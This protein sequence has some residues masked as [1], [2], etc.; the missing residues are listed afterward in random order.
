VVKAMNDDRELLQRFVD[1]HDED[2]FAQIVARHL[3]L[4]YS[5]A[6][7]QVGGD[8]HLAQDVAQTVFAD[9][10]RKASLLV[11]HPVLAGW[12]HTSTHHAAA[13]AVRAER[14]RRQRE[15]EAHAMQELS[16][17]TPTDA[18]WARVRPVL[19]DA[20][21]RL[22]HTDRDALLLRFF[23]GRNFAE[24]GTAL[25]LTES[26]ARMR[27]E[28]AMEKLRG[29]LERR[30]IRSTM[31][32]LGAVL[33]TEAVAAP[34]AGLA[35]AITTSALAATGGGAAAGFLT[36]IGMSKIQ[37]SILAVAA[38]A[39][40]TTV[41]MQLH[42][43][44]K[45][46]AEVDAV[47]VA[48]AALPDLQASIAR[49][50]A[51]VRA[52]V[53]NRPEPAQLVKMREERAGLLA[54]LKELDARGVGVRAPQAVGAR[55]AP[56]VVGPVFD[57]KELDV[58]PAPLSQPRPAWPAELRGIPGDAVLSFVITP[59][60]EVADIVAED[61]SHP[62]YVLAAI[63]AVSGW[64]FKPGEKDGQAVNSRVTA[65]FHFKVMEPDWF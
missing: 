15:E 1:G 27:V 57:V 36:F 22:D 21:Q 47:P 49:I 55:G 48:V 62:A 63:D 5:A 60:G 53:A 16:R 7:R 44:A 38:A 41:G 11:R 51:D 8:A 34:P 30:G 29:M 64:K 2:A 46:R 42:A 14:R 18:D 4:V 65:P 23:E 37:I 59:S 28:R 45:L 40:M 26:G 39:G 19:D 61:G 31:A 9:L 17:N 25:A 52:Q 3:G 43:Q 13:N 58:K 56:V 12:L 54:K 6:L 10:A 24:V 32:A 20:L 33:A 50:E 35:L